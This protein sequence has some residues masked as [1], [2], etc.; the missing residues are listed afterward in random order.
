[1]GIKNKRVKNHSHKKLRVKRFSDTI[2]IQPTKGMC[3]PCFNCDKVG[4]VQYRFFFTPIA[5]RGFTCYACNNKCKAML[6]LQFT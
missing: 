3:A 5:R 6:L 4:R 1:M 2:S